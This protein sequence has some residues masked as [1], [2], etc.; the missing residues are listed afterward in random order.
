M[1][2]LV[3]GGGGC[4]VKVPADLNSVVDF[5]WIGYLR[6]GG[7]FGIIA[8]SIMDFCALGDDW[9]IMAAEEIFLRPG[10]DD[11]KIMASLKRYFC[12]LEEMIE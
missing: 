9:K 2:T 5:S 8:V 11:W 6:L 12:A 10:R 4:S 7:R 1:R 3:L